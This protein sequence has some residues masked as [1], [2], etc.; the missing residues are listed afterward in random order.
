MANIV[1]IIVHKR[2]QQQILNIGFNSQFSNIGCQESLKRALL[3]WQQHELESYILFV[4]VVKAYGT[5]NH[6]LI[7]SLLAKYGLKDILTSVIKKTT[8][9]V[10]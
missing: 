8:L 2:I 3:L 10:K 7:Y 5:A 6:N 9:T 4:D 1:S